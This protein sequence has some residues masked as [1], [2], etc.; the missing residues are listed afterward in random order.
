MGAALLQRRRRP[1]H[2]P[3]VRGGRDRR[4]VE[5]TPCLPGIEASVHEIFTLDALIAGAW[6]KLDLQSSIRCP[7]CDGAMVSGVC[8]TGGDTR[9][10][11]EDCGTQLS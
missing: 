8:A 1:R 2:S 3:G 10:D 7:V 11:C 6:E 9:G 5:R 4:P